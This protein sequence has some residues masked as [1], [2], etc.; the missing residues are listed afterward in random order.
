MIWPESLCRELAEKRCVIHVGS[1]L[2]CQC[3]NAAG[4]QPPSWKKLLSNL[5][6]RLSGDE[7]KTLAMFLIEKEQYLDAAEVIRTNISAGEY[8]SE[9]KSSFIT[10]GYQPSSAHEHIVKIA[11]KVFATTN[12]DTLMET[13]LVDFS[14]L[15]SFTQFEHSTNGLNDSIRSPDTILIKMHGC[16][17]RPTDTILGRSDY[18]RLRQQHSPFFE[19]VTSIYKVNTV[20]FLGCGFEDPDINLILENINISQP[21][22]T[23]PNYALLG[24]LSYGAKM[25]A[26]LKSQYNIEVIIYNQSDENDHSQF[27]V[28]IKD[29]YDAV[30]ATR[31]KHG[32]P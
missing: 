11:P 28:A 26:L 4:L 13:A 5:T 19:L 25:S 7:S 6:L 24:S 9:L 31:A 29:L 16:A 17:K 15:D 8:A 3:T 20:L 32:T 1:G 18:F 21:S 27:I 10:A 22:I 12:F 14:G 30:S 2:S 23:H